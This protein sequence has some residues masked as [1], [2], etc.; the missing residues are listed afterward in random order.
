M[1]I[2]MYA[3]TCLCL[4][5]F[6]FTSLLTCYRFTQKNIV[7]VFPKGTRIDSSNY[8]P[9]IGWVHGAQMVAFNMQVSISSSSTLL[10]ATNY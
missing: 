6:V 9:L 3:C 1:F 2:S 10:Q 4:N 8:N 7:R 5:K